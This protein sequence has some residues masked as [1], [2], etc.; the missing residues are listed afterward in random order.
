M[1]IY[2]IKENKTLNEINFLAGLS[3]ESLGLASVIPI[4][5]IRGVLKNKSQ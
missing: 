3:T 1:T 4:K 2:P 5:K